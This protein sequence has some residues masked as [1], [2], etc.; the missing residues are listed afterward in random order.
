MAIAR[1]AG[2]QHGVVTRAQLAALGVGRGAVERRVAAGRL[3]RLHRGVY[4]VGHTV[5][6]RHGTLIAAVLACGEGAVLSH[7]SAAEL[8]RI[9]PWSALLDVTAPGDRAVPGVVCH[10]APV[11]RLIRHAIPVTTPARTLVDLADLLPR[12]ALER[13][14]GEAE[15]LRLDLGGL[16][17][18]AGRRGAG[19]V[20]ALLAERR[21]ESRTRSELEE[22]FLA[23]C[24]LHQ[25]TPPRT[26]DHVEGYEVDALWHDERLIVE[27]DGAQAHLTRAAFEGDRRRDAALTAAGYRVMRL[28]HRR[29]DTDAA[30]VARELR[31][32]G[33]PA[34]LGRR[35]RSRA[36]RRRRPRP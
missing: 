15:Y 29:L 11:S 12:R 27:L 31:R 7:R 28:T 18:V 3:H 36:G 32:A 5:L 30:E 14:L 4:A 9:G 33:A 6:T 21:P 19:A 1:L 2:R 16:R 24:S 10:R 23:L 8:W 22:M 25:L 13:A 35:S 20:A 17:P 26:N 34:A